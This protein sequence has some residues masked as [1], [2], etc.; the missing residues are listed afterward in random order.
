MVFET[1][2]E[3]SAK[4]TG[5]EGRGWQFAAAQFYDCLW[6]WQCRWESAHAH[7]FTCYTRGCRRRNADARPLCSACLQADDQSIPEPLGETRSDERGAVWRFNRQ[8]G[9]RLSKVRRAFLRRERELF[10]VRS[11][12]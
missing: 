12:S 10:R 5:H 1:V 6:R 9:K 4:A 7:K 2:R 11:V 3:I 8:I